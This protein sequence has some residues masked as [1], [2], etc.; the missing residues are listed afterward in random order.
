MSR[1]RVKRTTGPVE[2]ASSIASS[3]DGGPSAGGASAWGDA[4]TTAA[5]LPAPG[6]T[7]GL[8]CAAGPVLGA[9]SIASSFNGEAS[10]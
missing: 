3:L 2:G 1:E 4:L 8:D 5:Q 10:G 6:F 9:S 7:P